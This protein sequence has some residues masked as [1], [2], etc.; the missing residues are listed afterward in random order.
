MT[1]GIITS[2]SAQNNCVCFSAFESLSGFCLF[3]HPWHTV[4]AGQGSDPSILRHRCCNTRSLTHCDLLGIE[5][6]SQCSRDTADSVLPQWELLFSLFR[7]SF[8]THSTPR[9]DSKS[10]STGFSCSAL[11]LHLSQRLLLTLRGVPAKQ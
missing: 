1:T 10:G 11:C 2:D 9:P 5:P 6:S 4:F 7:I 3:S 8:F